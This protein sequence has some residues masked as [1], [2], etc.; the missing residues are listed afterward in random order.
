MLLNCGVRED[1]WEFLGL[2]GV[3]TS[4]SKGNQSWIFIGRTDAEAETP[5]L[6]PPDEKNWLILK[7]CDAGKRLKAGGEEDDRGW[8][9][10]IASPTWWTW[11]WVSSRSTQG[12][13]VYCRQWG[14]K[15]SDITKWLNWTDPHIAFWQRM[16]GRCLKCLYSILTFKL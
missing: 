4:Q 16:Y 14:H 10:W 15:E 3:W 11:V 6:W 7:D 1:S 12:S 2:Q 8:D 5:V 9:G 13:L